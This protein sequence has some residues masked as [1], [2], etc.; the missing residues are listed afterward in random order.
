MITRFVAEPFFT[1]TAEELRFL[2]EGPRVLQNYPGGAAKLGWVAIQNA[3]GVAEGS[4][5]ILDLASREN[6]TLPLKGRP[7]FF[8][9]TAEPGMILVGFERELA[10]FNLL[11]GAMGET[12]AHIDADESVI[13]N[14]GLAVEGGV[15]FGTKHL[16]FNKPIAALYFYDFA[17]ARSTLF[18]ID[19]S[20]RT[21][22]ICAATPRAPR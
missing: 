16:Q 13:I 5:N 10:Y 11:T 9:E 7:G 17:R 1:P 19:K 20:A 18:S 12:V 15:L 3:A 21:A 2:P 22:N 6:T 14:D 4:V 8:A